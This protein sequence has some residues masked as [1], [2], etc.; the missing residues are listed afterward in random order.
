MIK[1][2][3]ILLVILLGCNAIDLLEEQGGPVDYFQSVSEGWY[4]FQRATEVS[5][6]D[7]LEEFER[8]DQYFKN[9]LS[10]QTVPG[11][12][13]AY[14][15]L[16]WN[17]MYWGNNSTLSGITNDEKRDS[18]KT[19]SLEYLILAKAE[20]LDGL[21]FEE[22]EVVN[23]FSG[24]AY[25]NS[26]LAKHRND[27]TSDALI[28]TSIDESQELIDFCDENGI[29]FEFTYHTEIDINDIY[30]LRVQNYLRIG[31]FQNARD[32]ISN[33]NYPGITVEFYIDLSE[34]PE[35]SSG[36][37]FSEEISLYAGFSSLI[38]HYYYSA[39]FEEIGE[40]AYRLQRVFTPDFPCSDLDM[41][42]I[43]DNELIAC[44]N[45]FVSTNLEY[46]FALGEISSI[47]SDEDI[48]SCSENNFRIVE[49]G[50]VLSESVILDMV[51]FGKCE[52]CSSQ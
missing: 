46:R 6:Q 5:G 41:S 18:L 3:Y 17:Q 19:S 39:D 45:T 43:S 49:L 38:N 36:D 14:I 51:C 42:E 13:A 50:S 23:M 44:M 34:E 26:F 15:G 24:L 27:D 4:Y 31:E 35:Y 22:D 9:A 7:A 21:E 8:A 20:Y 37:S 29:E 52:P 11:Y 47:Y 28:Q 32:E 2:L 12:A 40:N 30:K 33:V 1:K 48:N 25:A 10:S 16:G